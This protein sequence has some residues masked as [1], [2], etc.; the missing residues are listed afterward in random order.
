M[1]N[2]SKYSSALALTLISVLLSPALYAENEP[3]ISGQA[4]VQDCGS[5]FVNGQKVSLWGIDPLAPDQQCWQNDVAWGCGAQAVTTL[6]HYVDGLEVEC[7]VI[8]NAE[9]ETP[10]AICYRNQIKTHQDIAEHLIR[11]GFAIEAKYDSE[12][13]YTDAENE[14]RTHK[15]GIWTSRFQTA[16]N[17]REGIQCFVGEEAC[18]TE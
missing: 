11:Q 10:K 17:W 1:M 18:T 2:T 3:L 14:A 5:L 16:A 15:R 4:V 13:T 8:E 9:Q 6:Q 7:H 12:N